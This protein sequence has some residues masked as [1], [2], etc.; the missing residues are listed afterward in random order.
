MKI[1]LITCT[2]NAEAVLQRT[3]DSVQKQ[4]YADIEHLI[5]DGCSKDATMTMAQR[6]CDASETLHNGHAVVVRSEPDKGLYDAMNKGLRMA[7]GDVVGILNADDM[8]NSSH[9]LFD[10]MQPF[11]LDSSLDMVYSDVRFVSHDM[12]LDGL[13]SGK[14]VRYIKPAKWH[15]WMLQWGIAPPHPGIYV[16]RR[17]FEEW[18][19]YYPNYEITSDYEMVIRFV[20]KHCCKAIYLPTC[21]VAMRLGGK[22]TRGWRPVWLQ[23]N[24]IV[25]ANRRNG[26]FC[27]ISMMVPKYLFKIFEFIGKGKRK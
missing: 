20:R 21:S 14:T 16:K 8:M 12:R 22:S 4:T 23:N 25:D 2:Y 1:T 19:Y 11:L 15:P 5:I 6:Y 26:Y 27:C 9:A 18:G 13:D 7:T 3:L 10:A 17:C 24:E